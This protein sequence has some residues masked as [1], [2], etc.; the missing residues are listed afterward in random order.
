MS[1]LG[2]GEGLR[3]RHGSESEPSS[4]FIVTSNMPSGLPNSSRAPLL[5]GI[6]RTDEFR[7]IFR[8]LRD[9]RLMPPNSNIH[10]KH[11]PKEL[12]QTSR[13]FMKIAGQ[14]GRDIGDT[15]SK[16][17]KLSLL[18]KRK[19]IFDD[20]PG[21]VQEL[22][23]VIKEDMNALNKQIGQ[24]QL[25]AAGN[26]ARNSSSHSKGVVVSLQSKLANMTSDFKRILRVRTENLKE[27]KSRQERFSSFNTSAA[28]PSLNGSVLAEEQDSQQP[29]GAA[30]SFAIDMMSQSLM[31]PTDH[32]Q[33]RAEAMEN[34]ESTIVELGGIFNQLAHMIKEQEE[35]MVRID[36]NIDD[37]GMNVEAGH[38]EILKYFQ[39]VTANRW[40]MIK[41]FGVLIFFFIFFIL[42][43]A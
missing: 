5:G 39:S 25:L 24:L 17:E 34:I 36:G 28:P 13:D 15:Y 20:S 14:I 10:S 21:D 27:S 31:K 30:P 16:L 3:R 40:L 9:K 1:G 33:S 32:L 19:T 23:Y 37:A 38:G 6:D 2:F 11:H 4:S 26:A 42:F 22:T 7:S 41:V 43:M 35:V 18:A 12:I 8:S 29:G